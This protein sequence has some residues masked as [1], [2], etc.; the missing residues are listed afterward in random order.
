M[1]ALSQYKFESRPMREL[2]DD[3][4]HLFNLNLDSLILKAMNI[5]FDDRSDFVLFEELEKIFK[6]N[7]HFIEKRKDAIY[8]DTFIYS[9]YQKCVKKLEE[10]KNILDCK[11]NYLK[12]TIREREYTRLEN[13]QVEHRKSLQ[14]GEQLIR[15]INELE[16]A[17]Q[18]DYAFIKKLNGIKIENFHQQEIIDALKGNIITGWAER[19]QYV[20]EKIEKIKDNRRFLKELLDSLKTGLGQYL[21]ER[22]KNSYIE[23]NLEDLIDLIERKLKKENEDNQSLPQ[24][25]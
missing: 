9:T 7:Q 24:Y 18:P 3:T 1:N 8:R 21:S 10:L 6:E 5:D 11:K 20:Y 22:F 19:F 4:N 25:L 2:I 16:C 17:F 15:K 13:H 12:D 14:N 23:E